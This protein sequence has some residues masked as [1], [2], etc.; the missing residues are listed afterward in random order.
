MI[1]ASNH[2]I[3]EMF[4]RGGREPTTGVYYAES[5]WGTSSATIAQNS[6]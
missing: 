6:E 5:R 1:S 4:R 2:S 3:L